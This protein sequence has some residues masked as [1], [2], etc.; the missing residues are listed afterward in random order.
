M[1]FMGIQTDET[2]EFVQQIIF[3]A[4]SYRYR[5]ETRVINVVQLLEIQN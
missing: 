4:A 5:N 3:V 2:D 1:M